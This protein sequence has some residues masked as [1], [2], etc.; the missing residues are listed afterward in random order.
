MANWACTPKMT[1]AFMA[2]V[3]DQTATS[4]GTQVAYNPAINAPGNEGNLM[5]AWKWI[6]NAYETAKPYLHTAGQIG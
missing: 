5:K 2:N 1:D 6:Q 4:I 3:L